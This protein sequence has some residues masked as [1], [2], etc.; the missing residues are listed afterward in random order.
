MS[1]KDAYQDRKFVFIALIFVSGLILIGKAAYIQLFD[2]KYSIKADAITIDKVTV[3]PARGLI[4]DR[5]GQLL[6]NNNAMYDLMVTYKEVK[7]EMDTAAFCS[8]L[9][10]T[11]QEYLER[12]EKDWKDVQFSKAVPFAFIKNLSAE[13]YAR[14]QDRLPEFPG[15][16]VQLRNA[17]RYPHS[18]A[19]HLL[20]YMNEA[21]PRQIE[22]GN[23]YYEAGDYIGSSGLE[24]EYEAI[25]RGKK[26]VNY[27]LRDNHGRT[28]GKYKEGELDTIPK[29]GKDLIS[30]IDLDLQI[31]GEELLKGK[32]GSIVAIEPQT[33]E[34]LAMISS[35]TYD[36]NLLAI[37]KDR[38]KVFQ[39][40]LQD[41]MKPFFDRSV[42]AKYPPG[43]IFKTVVSLVALQEEVWNEN[44]G[45]VCG[46]AYYYNGKRYGCHVHPGVG[47]I[48]QAIQY[49]C[50]SYYFQ[51][52]R[53]II[54]K[55]GFSNPGPGLD[56]MKAFLGRFGLG[57]K[58]GIDFP[59]ENAGFIPGSNYYDKIYPKKLGGWRSPYIM[60]IGIGQGEIQLTSIQMA[61]LAAAIANKGW[62]FTP[63]LIRKIKD[64]TSIGESFKVRHNTLVNSH[65]FDP[66]I[67]GME[68]VVL[69]G[70]ARIAQ[71]K[72]IT[73]CGK[74]GTSQNPQGEDHSV[75]FGF[76]PR[77]SPKIAI[78]VYVENAGFGAQYAAPIASLMMEKYL[79]GQVDPT[80]KP[81]EEKLKKA[82]T[83]RTNS[84]VFKVFAN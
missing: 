63:H 15:F 75:F 7:P 74:T 32:T 9:G 39:A 76:A 22:K 42:M 18:H 26:G 61:N 40:L 30:S 79:K 64:G 16:F 25:L 29:S 8:V 6:T 57:H 14:F 77:E 50:N 13:Q 41:S 60:S 62:Y 46:G 80:R 23:G 17:R 67:Q 81:L 19:A 69:A 56:S 4:Y 28:V 73:V 1:S 71:I 68:N 53:T 35:P 45:G 83:R 84:G 3:Y 33:G 78:S 20:G 59:N 12:L 34:I 70:T 21:T 47:N 55:Y 2:S 65:W 36:P 72:D 37:N 10:I 5:K 11:N 31:Y 27:M 43:S 54:D 24:Q 52:V 58:L 38:G 66:I 51:C 48:S 82:R 49:S 44:R